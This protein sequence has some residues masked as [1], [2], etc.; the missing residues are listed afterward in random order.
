M[1][2]TFLA[3][4]APIVTALTALAANIESD[5]VVL[6]ASITAVTVAVKRSFVKAVLKSTVPVI[7]PKLKRNWIK[8][9][10]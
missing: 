7:L 1:A 10:K 9:W 4:A 3:E 5:T 8:L 6:T 2:I